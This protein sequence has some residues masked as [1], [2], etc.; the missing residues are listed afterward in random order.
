[1]QSIL[2]EGEESH[3]VQP[4]LSINESGAYDLSR[5]RKKHKSEASIQTRSS[6]TVRG[7]DSPHVDASSTPDSTTADN[8]KSR[9]SAFALL[10]ENPSR[11]TSRSRVPGLTTV[12]TPPCQSSEI[13]TPSKGSMYDGTRG[14]ARDPL[15]EE[16]P[17]LYIGPSS[18][19]THTA[20]DPPP[21]GEEDLPPVDINS[22][23]IVSESPSAADIDIYETAYREEIER[24]R[25]RTRTSHFPA[26]KVYLTRRVDG[27][28][29]N[30]AALLEEAKVEGTL[31]TP[32]AASHPRRPPTH[33]TASALAAAVSSLRASSRRR[34]PA[35][36]GPE[37]EEEP[38]EPLAATVTTAVAAEAEIATSPTQGQPQSELRKLLNR[39]K[40]KS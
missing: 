40:D 14:H 9:P 8:T 11:T 1:M 13:G 7:I 21:D 34:T 24:I 10:A 2:G 17:Y 16:H 26:P 22:T 35:S 25:N 4:P 29:S 36:P 3:F 33:R 31:L 19:S 5:D 23:P 37:H 15:E 12:D 28:K 18:F 20:P 38:A 6:E 27:G 32:R 39:M 30:L